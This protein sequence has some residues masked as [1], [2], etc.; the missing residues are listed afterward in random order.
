MEKMGG[1]NG[2]EFDPDDRLCG[3]KAKSSRSMSTSPN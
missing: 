1:L 3:S 2:F